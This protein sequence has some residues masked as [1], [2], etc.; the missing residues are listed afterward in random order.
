MFIIW[1]KSWGWGAVA[2]LHTTFVARAFC[3]KAFVLIAGVHVP[4]PV[5][6]MVIRRDVLN[7]YR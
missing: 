5:K 1:C 6:S 3:A 4:A 2:R 7:D